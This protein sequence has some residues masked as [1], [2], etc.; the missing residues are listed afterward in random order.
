MSR[1]PVFLF[2]LSSL[3]PAVQASG[4]ETPV[5]A[6][7]SVPP[8]S[9]SGVPALFSWGDVD[10][11]GRLDLVAVGVD[12]ELQLL[13]G[14]GEGR[15]EDVTE[16]VGLEPIEGATL[17]VC[18]DYDGDGRLD[19]FVGARQ[20]ASRLYRNEGAT[21]VDRSAESGIALEGAVESAQWLDAEDD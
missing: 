6:M 14:V 8:S 3:S 19:L 5:S 17:A 21:F 2:A 12:G 11:D 7:A 10:G 9:R 16:R 15:F 20:G 4:G 18:A 1:C 13:T